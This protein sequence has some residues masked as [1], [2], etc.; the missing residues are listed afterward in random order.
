[1]QFNLIDER[2]IPVIRRD[3]KKTMIAPWEVT[4][5]FAENPL[6]SIDAPRPDFNGAL[7]QFLIGLVQTVAA[8]QNGSEW[9]KRLTE[10]PTPD[11]L[12]E[13][14]TSVRH[15]FELGGDGPRY[16]QNIEKLEV[17]AGGIDGLLIDMP[18]DSTKKH[19][20]DHFVKRD[21]VSVMCLSCSATALYTM[22]TNAPAGG[23]GFRTSIRG[24]GPLS[25]L[26]AGDA[27]HS[28]LWHLIWLNILEENSFNGICGNPVLTEP[29]AKFPWLVNT[30][31]SE[32]N[33]GSEATP[34]KYH[35]TVMYWGM[36][37]RIRLDL[38]NLAEGECDVCGVFSIS[39]IREYQDKN[40][41][42][43]FTGAWMH[44]LSPYSS[45]EGELLSAHA[46]PG[47]VSYRHWLGLVQQDAGENRM[48]ARI[49]HEF[50]DRRKS[51]WQFRLWAFGY[52]M[53]NMKA[54]CWYEA[55]IPLLLVDKSIRAEY[56]E[57]VGGM[58]RVA[59]EIASNTR[60][61]LKKAWFRRPGDAK[62][63]TTFV[64]N[65][66]WQN[67]EIDFYTVLNGM[68]SAL[69]SDT[70]TSEVGNQW[71][72]A[73][74][75]QSLNLFDCYAWEGAI[76]DADP[77]RVVIARKELQQYNRSKKIK[78]LLGIPVD[79]SDTDKKTKTKKESKQANK[80]NLD[81]NSNKG[82][83]DA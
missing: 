3:G 67:T 16:M 9:R 56:E 54:R 13:K 15:A 20:K 42:M 28:T 68:K 65:S 43:N 51:G 46:Q 71:L 22:Q 24:G 62:G 53:E 50:Y 8:P 59:T 36:P 52:D 76:E 27:R 29:S 80:Q 41:G 40:Y 57:R 60:S 19:N 23:A 66:Y 73:L 78:G 45:K 18:G 7:I 25:T 79:Q 55:S 77:K 17:E 34:E 49:V 2:W 1:M 44:P 31:T 39:L 63:D 11:E 35:P 4:D 64:D 72:T 32:R 26:V 58:V 47:G 38:D 74:C 83:E 5:Q 14:F 10:P 33:T 30:R 12:K 37:R 75:N 70:D 82:K 6:V 21:T 69:E 81:S 61:A 48:P